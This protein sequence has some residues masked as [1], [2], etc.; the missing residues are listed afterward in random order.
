MNLLKTFWNWFITPKADAC[1]AEP[2]E[3]TLAEVEED[4]RSAGEL[5]AFMCRAAGVKQRDLE[6]SNAVALFEE[7][8]RGSVNEA[9]IK[10]SIE[11]FKQTH[12]GVNAKLSGRI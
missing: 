10:Q 1:C 6:S 3:V 7:W 12:T 8:Y 4:T 5:F 11:E 2:H 9:E